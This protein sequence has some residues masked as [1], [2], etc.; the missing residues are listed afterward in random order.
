M[1]NL[2]TLDAL[3]PLHCPGVKSST[4][5]CRITWVYGLEPNRT[6]LII[7]LVLVHEL[8]QGMCTMCYLLQY[9][10]LGVEG[11]H[12]L[13]DITTGLVDLEVYRYLISAQ[14]AT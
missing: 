14:N 11:L 9:C 13:I 3:Y 10:M 4:V 5:G 2:C 12:F 8:T 6:Y 7:L 1:T